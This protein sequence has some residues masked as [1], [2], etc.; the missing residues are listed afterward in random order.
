[1]LEDRLVQILIEKKLKISASESCTGGLFL[2]TLVKVPNVSKVLEAGFITYANDAKTKFVQVNKKTIEEF[3]VV[4]EAVAGEMARGAM[5]V[6]GADVG[7]GISGIAGPSGGTPT[8]PVGM[9]CFGFNLLNK[10]YTFT[11]V[12]NG[13]RNSVRKKAVKFALSKLIELLDSDL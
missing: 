13:G 3:G 1:M 12:F 6:A 8:K 4:S 2:A 5:V 9:V 11:K 7:V 10:T